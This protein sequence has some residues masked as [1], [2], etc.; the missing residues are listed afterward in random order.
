[1]RRT[2]KNLVT[3]QT[4]LQE[5]FCTHLASPSG[6]M[7]AESLDGKHYLVGPV[8]MIR[9]G[10]WNDILYTGDELSKFAE[11][12]NGRPV[13]V[14]HPE[15]AGKRVSANQ[16]DLKRV[17]IG[18]VYNTSY[19]APRLKGELWLEMSKLRKLNPQ[20]AG[21]VEAGKP[22]EVST[23]LF[24]EA[25]VQSGEWQGK[26]YSAISKNYRP[27]HLALLPDEKGACS[28]EAGAGFPR[29]NSKAT[30]TEEEVPMDRKKAVAKLVK[31]N[32]ATNEEVTTLEAM[33]ADAFEMVVNAREE[34]AA[35]K[36][37]ATTKKQA[38]DKAEA[39][40]KAEAEKQ[41]KAN[42]EVEVKKRLAAN[43][44]QAGDREVTDAELEALMQQRIN[45]A[46]EEKVTK[47]VP[48]LVKN[49]GEEAAKRE[50]VD[51]ITAT[52]KVKIS[53]KS[54]MAMETNELR[55]LLRTVSPAMAL[56]YGFEANEGEEAEKVPEPP[57]VDWQGALKTLDARA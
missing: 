6:K 34:A 15:K 47:L 54:L 31:S 49:A 11:A 12:W 4:A 38:D 24:L 2:N 53:E 9:E 50:L 40:A 51:E 17:D 39:D 29:T 33:D 41:F 46:V 21:R 23:G 42:V 19:E 16:P 28:W 20:L 22:I 57:K 43:A 30:Q 55:D 8:V 27:D 14:K 52:K 10:V 44:E 32:L 56:R 13:T 25:S 1:M 7:R 37:E 48:M 36:A 3:N 45:A 26:P 18:V 35:A 5:R